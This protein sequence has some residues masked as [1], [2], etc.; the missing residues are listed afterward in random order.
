VAGNQP[1]DFVRDGFAHFVAGAKMV[2]IRFNQNQA[3]LPAEPR[4]LF[5]SKSGG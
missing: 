5:L 3:C 2:L 4:G 1:H